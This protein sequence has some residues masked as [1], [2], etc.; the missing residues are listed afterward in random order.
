MAVVFWV[1]VDTASICFYLG[2]RRSM[3]PETLITSYLTTQKRNYLRSCE[4]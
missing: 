2:D 3:F 1:E 4:L